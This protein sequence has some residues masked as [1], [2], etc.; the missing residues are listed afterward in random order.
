M[1]ERSGLT[2]T[3]PWALALQF[4]GYRRMTP[5]EKTR[6]VQELT[7]AANTLALAGL[8]QRHPEADRSTLLLRLAVLRLGTETVRR[9]YGSCPSADGT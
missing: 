2:D 7:I 8:K 5:A 9:A 3:A 6:R 4:E 1:V